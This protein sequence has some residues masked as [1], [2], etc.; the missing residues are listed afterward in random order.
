M[1]IESSFP[2]EE[3]PQTSSKTEKKIESTEDKEERLRELSK[4]YDL[5]NLRRTSKNEGVRILSQELRKR[6]EG[7]K[8]AKIVNNY[9]D[10]RGKFSKESKTKNLEEVDKEY[11]DRLKKSQ[12]LYQ[13]R[14]KDIEERGERF[15]EE[16][17]QLQRDI[18]S[19]Q[20]LYVIAQDQ[21]SHYKKSQTV[22]GKAIRLLG[23]KSESQESFEQKVVLA[24]KELEEM[25]TAYNSRQEAILKD[26]QGL[27]KDNDEYISKETARVKELKEYF[28]SERSKEFDESKQYERF[29]LKKLIHKKII[30]DR[31]N[32]I[33]TAELLISGENRAS[34]LAI[35]NNAIVVH[36]IPV[37]PDQ[38]DSYG[39]GSSENN[40]RVDNRKITPQQRV[41]IINEIR[42]DLACSIISLDQDASKYWSQGTGFVFSLILDGNIMSSHKVDSY[43]KTSGELD[44]VLKYND[45][46]L[47]D[48]VRK[49][50]ADVA[51]LNEDPGY[52]VGVW[53]ESIVSSPSIKALLINESKISYDSEFE[54]YIS[55]AKNNY[56][57]K[58]I[59]FKRKDGVFDE[60]GK[61]V[62]AKDIYG[63]E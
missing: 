41:S 26:L 13:K 3:G 31:N 29:K 10:Y 5:V 60:E 51:R 11:E 16:L 47:Q 18:D 59:Y 39:G 2:K 43:T 1:K 27:I 7:E 30:S 17:F 45:D 56:P 57:D 28:L 36:S 46:T 61:L 14:K 58:K 21:L 4:R 22:I 50:F 12:E 42:P 33:N 63:S 44:R 40:S 23:A 48:D 54:R 15:K 6:Y 9:L 25:Q 32:S 19:K 52:N 24:K 37:F 20:E 34:E 49:E 55:F 35:K 53:N 38:N 8:R 62:T